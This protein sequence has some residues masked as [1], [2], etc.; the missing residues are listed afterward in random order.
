MSNVIKIKSGAAIEKVII[1]VSEDGEINA[2]QSYLGININLEFIENDDGHS[3]YNCKMSPNEENDIITISACKIW[4]KL[5]ID[6][7]F[8]AISDIVFTYMDCVKD[9]LELEYLNSLN[10]H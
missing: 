1:E 10:K 4:M 8:C 9:A 3:Y 6:A 2:V 5:Y 7:G